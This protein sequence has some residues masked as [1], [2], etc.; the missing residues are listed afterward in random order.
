MD[1][2]AERSGMWVGI[3][4]GKASLHLCAIDHGGQV[5]WHRRTANDENAIREVIAQFRGRGRRR[6]SWA[7]DMTSGATALVI[8]LLL[9][10][11]HRVAYVPGRLVSRIGGGLAG[12]R[13]QDRSARR[14]NDRRDRADA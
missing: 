4:V 13:G 9:G 1:E 5:L 10:A 8:T 6:V 12:G 7:L 3:D 2:P 14:A 11:G